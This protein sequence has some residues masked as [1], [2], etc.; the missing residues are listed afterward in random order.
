MGFRV[1]RTM[2][3]IGIVVCS[4]GVFFLTMVAVLCWLNP[5][6]RT[7]VLPL[8]LFFDVVFAY[9]LF[10]FWKFLRDKQRIEASPF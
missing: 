8:V 5:D 1:N 3:T 2:L 4:L 7:N 10:R 9:R 6:L